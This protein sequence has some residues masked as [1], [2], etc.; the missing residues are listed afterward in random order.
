[1]IREIHKHEA[2]DSS[3][4]HSGLTESRVSLFALFEG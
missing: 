4:P 1:M 2:N 3:K